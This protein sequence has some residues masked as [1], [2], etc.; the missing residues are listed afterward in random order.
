V[1]QSKVVGVVAAL[2]VIGAAAVG[3]LFF[4]MD[5]PD[6]QAGSADATVPSSATPASTSEPPASAPQDP[7]EKRCEATTLAVLRAAVADVVRTGDVAT[8][9]ERA[10][11]RYGESSEGWQL[12][13]AL[14]P[15][16]NAQ[17][18]A[19]HGVRSAR[20][21][22]RALVD[23]ACAR[24][25]DPGRR[26]DPHLSGDEAI[27]VTAEPTPTTPTTSAAPTRDCATIESA[28]ASF[29][30]HWL[31]IEVRGQYQNEVLTLQDRLNW[32]GFG[33][34]PEDGDFGPITEEAVIRFQRAYGLVI[35]GKVG[36]ETWG[37]LYWD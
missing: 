2:I 37:A 35:D 7:E 33:C 25:H 15:A 11:R 4:F 5:G 9:Y 14:F 18:T 23:D 3:G 17:I 32:L 29:S 10:T 28:P 20:A 6:D 8:R 21:T 19:G 34:I 13:T 36:P 31:S 24:L 1:S 16:V 26:G 22:S 12:A 30:G 27:V